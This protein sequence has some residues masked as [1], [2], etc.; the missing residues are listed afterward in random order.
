MASSNRGNVMQIINQKTKDMLKTRLK[1][2]ELTRQLLEKRM[3]LYDLNILI[4][5]EHIKISDLKIKMYERMNDACR[6]Y[7]KN[8][9]NNVAIELE[10]KKMTEM[11]LNIIRQLI[12]LDNENLTKTFDLSREVKI[13]KLTDDMNYNSPD[14]WEE[15]KDRLMTERTQLANE[16][17]TVEA[18]ISAFEPAGNIIMKK[19][20]EYTERQDVLDNEIVQLTETILPLNDLIPEE[21]EHHPVTFMKVTETDGNNPEDVLKNLTQE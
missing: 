4:D 21:P 19:I 14:K 9:K 18:E 17:K 12:P 10:H 3:K 1:R 13:G 6:L 15:N 2:D 16:I 20:A 5:A 11:K 7:K 8:R